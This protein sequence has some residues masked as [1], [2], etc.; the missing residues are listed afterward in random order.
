[1]SLVAQDEPF[2]HFSAKQKAIAFI[3]TTFF[4]RVTYTARHGLVKGMKRRG[5]LGWLPEWM[6]EKDTA[7]ISFLRSLDLAGKTVYDVGAFHGLMTLWFASR[8]NRVIAFEPNTQ[9]LKRLRENIGINRLSNVTIR[10]VAAGRY[11]G[12][13]RIAWNPLTPGAGR[14][15]GTGERT[16]SIAIST[17]DNEISACLAVPQFIK[18]DTEGFE[19]DVLR[20]AEKTLAYAHPEIFL[21][22]H[23]ES[24]SQK[25]ANAR[26][27]VSILSLAGYSR[28][29]HVE[30]GKSISTEN[31]ARAMRG[32]L[33]AVH[34]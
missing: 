28:I 21:E 19:A 20:G 6:S 29:V 27:I 4:D 2:V 30:S 26:E 18:I 22:V 24:I 23:G 8:A 15:H 1:M 34:H 12:T 14:I 3:S 11:C 33:Y 7:E 16:Q 10:P 13:G 32:H 31:A 5:G 17:I 25:Q 9:N